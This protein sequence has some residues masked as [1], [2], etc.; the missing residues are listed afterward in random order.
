[1]PDSTQPRSMVVDL[2]IATT[3]RLWTGRRLVKAIKVNTNTG[4]TVQNI[5]IARGTSGPTFYACTVPTNGFLD[6][7]NDSFY[8]DS[9]LDDPEFTSTVAFAAGSWM[10]II[11]G[12]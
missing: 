1:M 11:F 2:N 6:A 12:D 3:R 8:P 5:K 9:E 10:V 4:G 7:F